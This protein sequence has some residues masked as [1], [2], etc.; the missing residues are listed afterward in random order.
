MQDIDNSISVE[1]NKSLN[2]SQ[3]FVDSYWKKIQ[4][5]SQY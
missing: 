5:D 2:Y 1:E 4:K 3:V